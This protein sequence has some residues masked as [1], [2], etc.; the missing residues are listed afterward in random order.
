M[1]WIKGEDFKRINAISKYD[2]HGHAL[3]QETLPWGL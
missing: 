3:A 1:P 2:F